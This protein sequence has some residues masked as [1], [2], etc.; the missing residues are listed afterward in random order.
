M[1]PSS[2]RTLRQPASPGRVRIAVP[3]TT[4]SSCKHLVVNSDGFSSTL[5]HPMYEIASLFI[6]TR[7]TNEKIT[8]LHNFGLWKLHRR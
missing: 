5:I 7:K 1:Q 8:R 3:V 6:G 4:Q 2:G